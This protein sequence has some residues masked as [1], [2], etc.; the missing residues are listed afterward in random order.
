MSSDSTP[1][2]SATV[3]ISMSATQDLLM[4]LDEVITVRGY[5]SRSQALRD[6]IID[7]LNKYRLQA[8]PG[9]RGIVSIIVRV[10]DQI[11]FDKGLA[12]VLSNSDLNIMSLSR[13]ID[14]DTPI[15]L[16]QAD[17]TLSEIS[18]LIGK[19][20]AISGVES[21]EFAMLPL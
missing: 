4:Q 6:A 10:K 16:I 9:E 14:D 3:V 17:G 12:H 8:S 11:A 20:R 2:S 13:K 7:F 15:R 18:D 19:T 21:V 1:D 5:H